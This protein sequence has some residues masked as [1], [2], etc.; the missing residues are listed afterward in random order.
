M[1]TCRSCNAPVVWATSATSGKA[2]PLDATPVDD[3]NLFLD[4]DIAK[5]FKADEF[6]AL[7]APLRFVSHFVTCPQA[8][9]WRRK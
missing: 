9:Q 4:G 6:D 3:G 8:G 7:F 1:S 2:I 5:S